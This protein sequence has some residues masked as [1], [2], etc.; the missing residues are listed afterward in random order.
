V[1][2]ALEEEAEEVGI[3]SRAQDLRIDLVHRH[4]LAGPSVGGERSR[5][6]PHQGDLV[7][8]GFARPS[9]GT[10]GHGTAGVVVAGGDGTELLA[11][12][13]LPVDRRAV[14]EDVVADRHDA[15]EVGMEERLPRGAPPRASPRRRSARHGSRGS[16]RFPGS[17]PPPGAPSGQARSRC[18]GG[19]RPGTPGPARPPARTRSTPRPE[20]TSPP[21]GGPRPGAPAPPAAGAARSRNAAGKRGRRASAARTAQAAASIS[22]YSSRLSKSTGCQQGVEDPPHHPSRRED[23]VELGEVRRLGAVLG[24]S[25]RGRGGPPRPAR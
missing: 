12:R 8:A 16:A 21:G 1:S 3:G 9:A 4:G 22:G 11:Q 24:Q 25:G 14:V 18:R 5:P 20:R 2:P 19:R 17:R 13:L 6:Q 10:R 15:L 23:Q 7:H